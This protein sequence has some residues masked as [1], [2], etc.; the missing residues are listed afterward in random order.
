ME[1]D[2]DKEYSGKITDI[3]ETSNEDFFKDEGTFDKRTGLAVS[4]VFTVGEDDVTLNQFFGFPKVQGMKQSNLAL[5][6]KKYGSYPK[7]NQEV[8]VKLNEDGFFRI[9][10]E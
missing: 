6:K 1:A 10:L 3:A 2:Y 4:V 5:F 7:K 9:V 8:T